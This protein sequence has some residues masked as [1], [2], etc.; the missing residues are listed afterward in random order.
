MVQGVG[1][2]KYR[3]VGTYG[4]GGRLLVKSTISTHCS[5]VVYCI[6]AKNNFASHEIRRS[7]I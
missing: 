1:R 4:S 3:K 7:K 2:E 5:R 6:L